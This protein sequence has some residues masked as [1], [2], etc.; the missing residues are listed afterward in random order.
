MGL[1][2]VQ[3]AMVQAEAAKSTYGPW[4]FN[5]QAPD[6]GNVPLPALRELQRA[7]ALL[8]RRPLR[9]HGV[10]VLRDDRARS[11]WL[12]PH[13]HPDPRL[14]GRRGVDRL[15]PQVVH[16]QRPPRLLRHP[17]RPHRRRR[18][19][20]A[21]RQHRL[22]RR[23]THAGWTEV[24]DVETMPGGTTTPRSASRTCGCPTKLLGGTR[25]AAPARSGAASARPAWRTACAGSAR[26]RPRSRCSSTAPCTASRTAPCSPT[27]SRSSG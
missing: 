12:R 3:L 4:V 17:H 26:P 19:P 2:H 9:G 13:A 5:C 25:A 15:R 18:G 10:V 16:L 27:S 7:E 11:R 8:L 21:G 14:P 20:P 22:H 1:G 24:R 23:P 6:E